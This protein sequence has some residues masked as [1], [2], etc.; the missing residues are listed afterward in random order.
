VPRTLEE[1]ILIAR[2]LSLAAALLSIT[3]SPLAVAQSNS[4]LLWE[5]TSKSTTVYLLGTIH[6][7]NRA[8][9]PLS[10]AI[11]NAYVRAQVIALEADPTD[12]TALLMA[13]G[14]VMYQPPE[15]LERNVSPAL[16]QDVRD[17]LAT[18]GLPLELAQ[19]MKPFMV[20]MTLTMTEVSRLGFDVSLGV[21]VHLATRAR[22][23]GK[24]LVELESMAAQLA[25]LDAM[26]KETQVAMLE[27]TVKGLKTGALKRDLEAMI[28]AWRKGDAQRMDDAATR[29]LKTM[30]TRAGNELKD[31]LFDRRNRAMTDKIVQM[32]GGS[33]VVLVGVGAGHMTGS[34]GIVELLRARGYSVRRL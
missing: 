18:S 9:Y 5:V 3:G 15:T 32:L 26:P 2:L 7:G 27:S 8:M 14:T 23:D 33:E 13:L 31:A 20:S 17:A 12:P 21:D 34:S 10:P 29:D 19:N 22:N 1:S 6:V 24:R 25:L 4:P 16:Y 11:E 28:D 30:P